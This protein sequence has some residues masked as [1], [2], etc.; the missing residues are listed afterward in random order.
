[1]IL[2]LILILAA[3]MV[4]VGSVCFEVH[5]RNQGVL[6]TVKPEQ[7]PAMRSSKSIHD[8]RQ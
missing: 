5:K 7:L 6:D 4:L 1:M 3:T 2:K 8:Y